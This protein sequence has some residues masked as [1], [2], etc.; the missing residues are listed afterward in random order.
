MPPTL[1]L[2]AALCCLAAALAQ[3]GGSAVYA[4]ST[5]AVVATLAGAPS[6]ALTVAS[7]TGVYG[8]LDG[9][10]AYGNNGSS[11]STAAMIKS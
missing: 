6:L 11:S 4:Q 2:A 9:V 5:G 8:L 7:N 10:L 1:R 3:Y